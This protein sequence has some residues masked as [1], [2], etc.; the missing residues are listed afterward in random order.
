MTGSRPTFYKIN[1]QRTNDRAQASAVRFGV[2]P[3]VEMMLGKLPFC[4]SL[5]QKCILMPL[6]GSAL[7]RGLKPAPS[8]AWIRNYGLGSRMFP[9][10]QYSTPPPNPTTGRLMLDFG[11]VRP[12]REK[13]NRFRP[14]SELWP[15]ANCLAALAR[16]TTFLIAEESGYSR[17]HSADVACRAQVDTPGRMPFL[18]ILALTLKKVFNVGEGSS[19]LSRC[20]VF[21]RLPSSLKPK[22]FNADTVMVIFLGASLHVYW[23]ARMPRRARM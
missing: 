1:A 22:P 11:N 10:V 14:T 7:C 8:E 17:D 2:P 20:K 4:L 15:H 21:P 5:C 6:Q 9:G 12:F 13:D 3:R 19:V 16:S 23:I 18:R